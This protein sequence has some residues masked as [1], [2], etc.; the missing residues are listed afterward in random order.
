MQIEIKQWG[1]SLAVRFPRKA[2]KEANMHEGDILELVS[3]N[4]SITLRKKQ[5][6][7]EAMFSKYAFPTNDLHYTRDELHER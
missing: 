2:L 4:G 7:L 3:E 1:N 5:H 6:D